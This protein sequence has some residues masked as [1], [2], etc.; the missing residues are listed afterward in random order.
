MQNYVSRGYI[1]YQHIT[2]IKCICNISGKLK[3]SWI[4]CE[5]PERRSA[6]IKKSHA[7][8]PLIKK[9]LKTKLQ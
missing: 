3:S 8:D 6:S 1:K 2:Q 7:S 4:Y 9:G 5:T